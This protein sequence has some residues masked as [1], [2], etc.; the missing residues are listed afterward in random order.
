MSKIKERVKQILE[1]WEKELNESTWNPDPGAR[2]LCLEFR[3]DPNSEVGFGEDK[4]YQAYFNISMHD[5]D[6]EAE[7]HRAVYDARFEIFRNLERMAQTIVQENTNND[8][9][10]FEYKM[11]TS[12]HGSDVDFQVSVIDYFPKP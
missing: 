1:E 3:A 2:E 5:E 7:F 9:C 10:S 6:N 11:D 4:N 12:H 8:P